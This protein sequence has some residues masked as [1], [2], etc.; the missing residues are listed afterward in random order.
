LN[1]IP[2]KQFECKRGVRQ[3]DPISHLFYLFGSN[4]LQS[5]LNDL[6]QQGLLTLPIHTNDPDFPI[7]QY[8]DD[9]LLILPADKDQLL[10][11]KDTLRKFSLSTGLKI[12][13]D[14]SQMLPINVPEDLFQEL[15]DVFQCQ[16]GKMPFTYLGLPV[17]TTKPTITELSPLVCR[18]ERKLTSSSSFLSQGARLQLINSAL[19]S[20]P[21]HFL[22]YLQLPIGLTNQ[23]D[24][25]LRQCL[26]RDKDGMPKQSLAAW[27]LVCKP[28]LKGGLG[29]VNFQK[30]N[31]ALLI[32]FLDKFYNRK[33]LPWGGSGMVC[34][35]SG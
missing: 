12:N 8:A 4:L 28:K 20:M 19:S 17:G 3:G 32:K 1:G 2:G 29:I 14:K 6:V 5:V 10:L 21:L 15:V 33:A 9:T 27:E 34:T 13:F 25:I 7:V 31:A 30:Q 11:I 23:L 18:L 26:W 24:R 22:C 16:V 35:L